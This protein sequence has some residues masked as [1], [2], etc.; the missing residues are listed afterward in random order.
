MGKSNS[1]SGQPIFTMQLSLSELDRTQ[2]AAI[3]SMQS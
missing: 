2:Q 3:I 1:L